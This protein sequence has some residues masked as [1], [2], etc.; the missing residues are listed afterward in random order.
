MLR[1]EV[2]VNE[3]E[4]ILEK[5]RPMIKRLKEVKFSMN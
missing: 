1:S 2:F 3:R 5:L 4:K